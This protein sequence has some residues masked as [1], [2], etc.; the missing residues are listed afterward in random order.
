MLQPSRFFRSL[1][2]LLLLNGL[3]KPFWIFF[4]DRKVQLLTGAAYGDYFSLL[5]LTLIPA[6]IADAGI[7]VFYT[8][9]TAADPLLAPFRFRYFLR[10]KIVLA[11]LYIGVAISIALLFHTGYLR[12]IIMLALLQV[13]SSFYLFFRSH[14]TALQMFTADAVFSVADKVLVI[15]MAGS[16]IY[17]PALSLR[18]NTE[19]FIEVQFVAFLIASVAALIFLAPRL[20][21]NAIR[22]QGSVHVYKEW[23]EAIPY[24]FVVLLMTIMYRFDAFLLYHL[25][26][27][28]QRQ[29]AAYAT[30]FRLLDALNMTGFLMASFLLPLL[31][32]GGDQ[33][34]LTDIVKHCTGILLF[35]SSLMACFCWFN[36]D[37]I[38]KVL[39]GKVYTDGPMVVATS[40]LGILGCSLV[41]IYSTVLTA[42]GKVKILLI[43]SGAFCVASILVNLV[44]IPRYGAWGVAVVATGLQ[45]LFALSLIICCYVEKMIVPEPRYWL[46]ALLVPLSVFTIFMLGSPLPLLVQLALA[47]ITGIIMSLALGTINLHIVRSAFARPDVTNVNPT[48]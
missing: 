22:P 7:L 47:A 27:E 5:H 19:L 37:M 17:I 35:Y 12:M 41:H 3:I 40:V 36:R 9:T 6:V 44:I 34:K 23:K 14:I 29:S 20:K 33:R 26:P 8:K 2:I 24:A 13:A 4:I 45:F 10:I 16:F 28:G 1:F 18:M 43:C 25:H 21:F 38:T 30:G 39:Y 42:A 31:S 11:L 48:P 15:L 46:K 32:R